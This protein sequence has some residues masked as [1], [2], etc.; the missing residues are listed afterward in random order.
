MLP[1]Q[2]QFP[3]QRISGGN[4]F[5]SGTG[6][7]RVYRWF[8]FVLVSPQSVHSTGWGF[9]WTGWEEDWLKFS[10][11]RN[12]IVSLTIRKD[13]FTGYLGGRVRT[14]LLSLESK[15]CRLREHLCCFFQSLK[16]PWYKW[17]WQKHS[18]TPSRKIQVCFSCALTVKH[19]F[20]Q[21]LTVNI[22][23]V[24]IIYLPVECASTGEESALLEL[25]A[26]LTRALR[27][28]C[29]CFSTHTITSLSNL[30]KVGSALMREMMLH[31]SH[32]EQDKM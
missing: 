21:E 14:A 25:L 23:I 22:L 31:S 13:T 6:L 12:L 15:C 19:I 16:Y 24:C 29:C 18:N 10:S 26:V 32:K 17:I 9:A 11:C 3:K 5:C 4:F 7:G 30:C 2:Q 27:A 1:F 28:W 8:T 20:L